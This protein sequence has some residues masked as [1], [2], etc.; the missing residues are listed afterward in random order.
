MAIADQ[1]QEHFLKREPGYFAGPS[2]LVIKS[3]NAFV[4]LDPS[5]IIRIESSGHFTYFHTAKE[6]FETRASISSLELVLQNLSFLRISRFNIVNL[7]RVKMIEHWF[8]GQFRFV[9]DDGTTLLATR[10]YR[11]RVRS[12]LDQ[13]SLTTNE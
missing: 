5:E 9:L 6:T 7:D 10:G 1:Q 8:R 2:R 12:I 3:R 13:T 4:F 11:D